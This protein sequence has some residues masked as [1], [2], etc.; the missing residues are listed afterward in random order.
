MVSDWTVID[1]SMMNAGQML[2]DGQH[3]A[4]NDCHSNMAMTTFYRK[5][6]GN[7]IVEEIKV[8]F[9]PRPVQSTWANECVY[10]MLNV[11]ACY[12][13]HKI[14]ALRVIHMPCV[15][16]GYPCW[17]CAL[18]TL[19]WPNLHLLFPVI[20]NFHAAPVVWFSTCC[21]AVVH[22]WHRKVVWASTSTLTS[23]ETKSDL[24]LMRGSR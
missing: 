6:T 7:E 21:P 14:K 19:S 18:V 16:V 22:P 12:H 10:C 11:T 3:M 24:T 2:I 4:A 20:S 5:Y 15:F 9:P 8:S 13:L 1:G 17:S 23:V